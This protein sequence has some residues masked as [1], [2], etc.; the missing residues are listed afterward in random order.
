[1]KKMLVTGASGFLGRRI[2]DFY[3]GKYDICAPT[4]SEMDITDE[5]SVLAYFAEHKPDIVIHCA[6]V[7]DVGQ[8]EREPERSWKIN[9]DGSINIAKA[10]ERVGAKCIICSSDQVY[11][12]S[13]MDVAHDEDEVINPFNL[14]G[15]GKLKAEQECLK[16]SPGCVLLRLSWMYDSKSLSEEEHGD[17]LRTLISKL[18]NREEISYPIYDKRGITDVS[19]VVKNLEKTFCIPGGVYNFGSPND[20]NTYD[21]VCAIFENAGLDAGIIKKNE[22]AFRDNPR[23]ITMS[24]KKINSLGI[25][26]LTTIDGVSDKLREIVL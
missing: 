25:C 3:R 24:Q 14:Y 16:V 12:G 5:A 26:F 19:E 20:K 6:A 11:F 1:M 4:H 18:E 2:I 8:C 7:S 21:T 15:Q 17:F 10:S 22:E 9:V 13:K 23:N